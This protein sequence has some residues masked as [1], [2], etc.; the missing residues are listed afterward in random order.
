MLLVMGE[1]EGLTRWLRGLRHS[2]VNSLMIAHHCVLRN[3]D[4]IPVRAIKGLTFWARMVSM[5]P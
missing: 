2:L 5:C 1:Y 3:W 4:R